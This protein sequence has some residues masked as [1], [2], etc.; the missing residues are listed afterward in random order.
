MV[1]DKKYIFLALILNLHFFAGCA[2][3]S[4]STD[5]DLSK[6]IYTDLSQEELP[7]SQYYQKL[8]ENFY[9]QSDFLNAVEMFR[10]SLLHDSEN[11]WS[12]FQL[13]KSLIMNQQD[14]LGMI[15]LEKYFSAH[16][17]FKGIDDKDMQL[18]SVVY[19]KSKSYEK[20][21]DVQKAYFE[22]S[23]SKWS[24]WKIYEYQ[25]FLG[26]FEQA[27]KTLDQLK[28]AGE[29]L[30]RLD[31]AQA[32]IFEQ[33]K[34]WSEVIASLNRAESRKPLD[35]FILRK[36]ILTHF[37]AKNWIALNQE[38]EKYNKYHPYNL[39]IS[40]KW[41]YSTI[42]TKDYDIALAELKKQKKMYPDSVGLEFKI[43][44]VLFLMKDYKSAEE[45]YADLYQ[46]TQSDQS[47]FYLAQIHMLNNRYNE[48]AEKMQLLASTSEYYPTSQV[49]LSRLEWKNSEK[50]LALNRMRA[51]HILRP[52]SLDLYIEYAQYLIWAKNYVEAIAL[53]EK[54]N[55]YY[56]QNDKIKLLS[57]Y[58]HF[59]LNNQK[60]FQKDIR[61]AIA[62]APNNA[63]IYDVL[64]ELWYEKQKPVSEIKYLA[65][66][67]IQLNSQS[68]NVKPIL[69]WAL[70]QQDQ[71]SKAAALF[72]DFYDKNPNEVF[73]AESLAEVY[74]R[75]S[76]PG[77][78]NNYQIKATELKL[79]N[80]LKNEIEFF[81]YQNQMQKTDA[82]NS[83]SRLPASLD[84]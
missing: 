26:R 23:K 64:S 66:K 10:L 24:L 57:A 83:K 68:K 56:P 61:M 19:E 27:F 77:K 84:Q 35:E 16:P 11:H 67:A 73:Y 80:Q 32:E 7:R 30:S 6:T 79:S 15:E 59:K 34:N 17:D 18:I 71:L 49:E 65:E 44:H 2:S 14:H 43:A 20:L 21:I 52:D 46:L 48:A 82:Q 47:V 25:I 29:D 40:E 62:L 42:Q 55:M 74:S 8:G 33:Q 81:S 51:A 28:L 53:L 4:T 37:E 3:V 78:T 36:K 5:I 76:L 39:E 1:W 60:Q 54:A 69:A 31:L 45:A 9:F 50:D 13:A 58:N 41:S 22:K 75:S 38:G 70:L 12:R 63:E 72:E